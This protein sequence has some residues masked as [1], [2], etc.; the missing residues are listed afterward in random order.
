M[1]QLISRV[2]KYQKRTFL[3]PRIDFHKD[4]DIDDN[5]RNRLAAG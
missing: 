2:K 4:G 5:V 3:L 1:S